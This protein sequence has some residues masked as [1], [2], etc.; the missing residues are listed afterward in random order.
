MDPEYAWFGGS[1]ILFLIWLIIYYFRPDLRKEMVIVSLI[2]TPVGLTGHL[3]AGSYWNP[4]HLTKLF[5]LNVGMADFLFTFSI[6]GMGAVFYQFL[7]DKHYSDT[8]PGIY[9]NRILSIVLVLAT[10][11]VVFYTLEYIL[12]VSLNII[13]TSAVGLLVMGLLFAWLYSR[14]TTSII[15]NGLLFGLFIVLVERITGFIFPGFFGLWIEG[16]LLGYYLWG[17]PVE[18]FIWHFAWGMAIGS[19]YEISRAVKDK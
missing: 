9:F 5:G 16:E 10:G 2:F 1:L 3:Y 7:L 19:V 8:S 18:E 13:I 4:D 17:V 6:S 14:Q 15:L 12:S 11:V